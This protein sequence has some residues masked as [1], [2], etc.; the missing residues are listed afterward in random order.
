MTDQIEMNSLPVGYLLS[1]YQIEKYLT[2]SDNSFIYLAIDLNIERRVIIKE[3]FPDALADR[4]ADFSVSARESH[5]AD[6]YIFDLNRFLE[7]VKQI[8]RLTQQ[9]KNGVNVMRCFSL[10]GTG[11][12]VAEYIAEKTISKS[13]D[14]VRTTFEEN[15]LFSGQHIE[16]EN[17]SPSLQT[18]KA[19]QHLEN[20]DKKLIIYGSAANDNTLALKT[21]CGR[22]SIKGSSDLM[23]M[24]YS[25]LKFSESEKLRIYSAHRQYALKS[26]LDIAKD[27]LL[28][29]LL[30]IDNRRK[31][32]LRDLEMFFS[33]IPFENTKKIAIGVTHID[34][35]RIP[36]ISDYHKHIQRLEIPQLQQAPVF[37]VNPAS[38]H[39]M[40]MLLQSLLY[41]MDPVMGEIDRNE[42]TFL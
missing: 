30:L 38:H 34:Q 21:L 25:S 41:S 15:A 9:S 1:E 14:T 24:E 12:M 8:A 27:K 32:P 39:D 3:F 16:S 10:N 18:S 4:E 19:K 35:Y 23:L 40:S 29:I 7:E 17:I 13:L 22:A 5:N 42:N 31:D 20:Q 2:Y 26:A 6:Q 36:A 28:G 37:S 33:N 11:Y